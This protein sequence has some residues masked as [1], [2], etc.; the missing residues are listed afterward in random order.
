M[1]IVLRL[2]QTNHVMQNYAKN[3][4]ASHLANKNNPQF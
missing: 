4:E 3:L 2:Y 1:I